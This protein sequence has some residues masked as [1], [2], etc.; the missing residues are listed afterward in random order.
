MNFAQARTKMVDNQIRTTDVTDLE[1]LRAFLTVPRERF[2]PEA[3]RELAYIGADVPLGRSRFL[4][5]ASP[6]AKLLQLA[7]V[8]SGERALDVGAGLGYATAVLAEVGASVVA[9]E[10]DEELAQRAQEA[11]SA[12]AAGAWELARGPLNAGWSA[13]APYDV[14]LVEG[15]VDRVPQVLF[16]QLADRGRLVAVIGHGNA[17]MAK[18]FVK[19]GDLVSDRFGFNCSLKPLPGFVEKPSFA[20]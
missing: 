10:E 5:E 17:G 11:L 16:D 20:F 19:D 12:S 1:L 4:M 14:I 2:V 13:G 8:R 7:Q 18:L 15:S 6:L 9:L 3:R